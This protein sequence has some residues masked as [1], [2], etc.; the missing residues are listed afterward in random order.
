[1]LIFNEKTCAVTMTRGDSESL[2]V[3]KRVNGA[4]D[5]FVAGETLTM[6]VRDGAEGEILF[7]KAVT[8]FDE[9]GAAVIP[10]ET[11]DTQGLDFGSYV[12]DIQFTDAAGKVRTL[13]PPRPGRLPKFTLTQEATYG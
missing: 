11:E 6:T 1:M 7:Q 10:I 3:R 13:I 4:A 5:A 9:S 8:E 12:Y 2:T